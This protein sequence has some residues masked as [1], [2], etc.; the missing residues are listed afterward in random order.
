MRAFFGSLGWRYLIAQTESHPDVLT[1]EDGGLGPE[2]QN[3]SANLCL[4]LSMK[5]K[6]KGAAESLAG[7]RSRAIESVRPPMSCWTG[8]T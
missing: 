5:V 6:G 1:Q 8:R 2:A 3:I 4:F 7:G